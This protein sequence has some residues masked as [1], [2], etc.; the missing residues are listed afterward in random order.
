MTLKNRVRLGVFLFDLLIC[1]LATP[2]WMKYL[3]ID[4]KL[5][6]FCVS[7]FLTNL[8]VALF[9]WIAKGI[10]G[11]IGNMIDFADEL[12]E[13]SFMKYDLKKALK[14]TDEDELQKAILKED[15]LKAKV[16]QDKIDKKSKK[17]L[18]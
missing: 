7:F 15:F 1:S 6:V 5:F 11:A 18:K 4:D 10:L 2:L 9:I 12:Y 16:I 14:L 3:N 13:D 8:F 17:H